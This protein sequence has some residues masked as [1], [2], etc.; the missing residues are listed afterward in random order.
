MNVVALFVPGDRPDRFAKAAGAGADRVIIDCEDA[1]SPDNKGMARDATRDALAAGFAAVVRINPPRTPFGAADLAALTA[2]PPLAILVPK[3]GDPAD[4]EAVRAV[5]PQTPVIALIES[6]AGIRALDR[7]A[8][9]DGI[10]ALAFG[11]FDLCAELGAR[12]TAEVVAPWRA[13][14]VLAARAANVTVID[15]PFLDID[16][17]VGLGEDAYRA[18]DFGF[19]G[20]FAIHP[21]Q[22]AT[23]RA[24]FVPDANEVARAR[25]IVAAGARGGASSFEGTMIDAPVMAAA[26]RVIERAGG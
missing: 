2:H 7:I 24:A 10:E 8:A 25:A 6:I 15:M 20:K 16:D 11:G 1:V 14:I 9:A 3:A 13:Q 5:L 22:I 19:D 4:I 18:V 23:I 21:K 17:I 12:V 26:R